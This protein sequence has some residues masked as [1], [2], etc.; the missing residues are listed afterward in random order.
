MWTNN[1]NGDWQIL[2]DTSTFNRPFVLEF[3][4]K[5]IKT[6]NG[7]DRRFKTE[8]AAKKWVDDWIANSDDSGAD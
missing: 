7:R 6:K 4:N 3:Q 1:R 2:K 8:A 5:V